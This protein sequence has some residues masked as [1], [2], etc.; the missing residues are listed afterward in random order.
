VKKILNY[1][2]NHIG[3]A[4]FAIVSMLLVISAD[5]TIPYI[6]EIF[7]DDVLRGKNYEINK[8]FLWIFKRVSI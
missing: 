6:T 4:I 5:L 3:V 1:L 7:I 2:K 8:I